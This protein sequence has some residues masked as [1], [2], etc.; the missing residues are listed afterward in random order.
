MSDDVL[1]NLLNQLGKRSLFRNEFKKF[2]NTGLPMF[3]PCHTTT[4]STNV[5]G[6]MRYSASTLVYAEYAKISFKYIR[7][8]LKYIGWLL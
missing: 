4:Y 2:N 5:C 3:R 6:R 1:L 8:M 7:N